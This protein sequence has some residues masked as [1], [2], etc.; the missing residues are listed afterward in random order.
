[1]NTSAAET[2]V[3]N[4]GSI[5]LAAHI[6]KGGLDEDRLAQTV[7][8]AMRMLDNVIDLNFYPTSEARE[9]SMRH[10]PVGLGIMGFQDALYQMDINFTSEECVRFADTS[11]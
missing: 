3:C 9:A 11:M 6:T 4:L 8:L 1:L 5:N 10:R 2:A 7:K